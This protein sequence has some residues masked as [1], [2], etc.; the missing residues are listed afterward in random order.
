MHRITDAG[1][2]HLEGL[3]RLENLSLDRTQV[4]DAGLLA[5]VYLIGVY[6]LLFGVLLVALALRL[7]SIGARGGVLPT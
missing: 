5:L 7:R 1:L 2:A 3:T 4:T 6:C